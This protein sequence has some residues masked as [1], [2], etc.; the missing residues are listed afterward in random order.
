[1][2]SSQPV[3]APTPVAPQ[4]PEPPPAAAAEPPLLE[5]E[6][7]QQA[8]PRSVVSA[9]EQ[10]SVPAGALIRN[11][12]PTALDGSTLTVEFPP[13][14]EQTKRFAEDPKNAGI[15]QEALYEVTGRKLALSFELGE[16]PHDEPSESEPHIA[17]EEDFV[18][19]I[20]DTFDAREVE[21]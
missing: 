13:S 20:K 12:R 19:L 2:V 18:S 17:S 14:A 11:G 5:L 1:M 8:W 4:P 7:L 6:Q 16:G 15:L 9:V 3:E 21:D 10:R